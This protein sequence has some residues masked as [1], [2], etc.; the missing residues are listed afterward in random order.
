MNRINFRLSCPDLL[1]LSGWLAVILIINA[2]EEVSG[3]MTV[4]SVITGGAYIAAPGTEEGILV[5]AHGPY[6][7]GSAVTDTYGNF[8]ISGLANGTYYLEYSMDGFGTMWQYDIRLYGNDTARAVYTQLYEKPPAL[9]LPALKKAFIGVRPR[10]NPEPVWICFDT[11][12]RRQNVADY[13]LQFMLCMSIHENVSWDNYEICDFTWSGQFNWDAYLQDDVYSIYIDIRNLK[14]AYR[15]IFPFPTGYRVYVKGYPC[16]KGESGGYL[17]T[18]LGV[19]QFSTL[20]KTRS[21]N[22]I[23]FIMP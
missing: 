20:D 9:K 18:Y 14:N 11:D 12:I 23:S 10:N 19:R 7:Q 1:A 15:E 2:C 17:D 13:G 21:T 22:T 3:P 8:T 16:N 6:G 5:V 4:N